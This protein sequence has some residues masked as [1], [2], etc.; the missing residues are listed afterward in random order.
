MGHCEMLLAVAGLDDKA[1]KERTKK[2]AD[3]DWSG[4]PPAER[5]AF[6][7]ARK[8][9]KEPWSITDADVGRTEASLRPGAGDRRDLVGVPVPLHD[10]RRRRVPAAA[11]AGERLCAVN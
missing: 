11:G 5:A 3:G 6:N 2:L 7:F 8:M 10:A 1:I 9:S 4:F